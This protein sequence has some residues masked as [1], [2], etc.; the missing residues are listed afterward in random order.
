VAQLQ[1]HANERHFSIKRQ[2]TICYQTSV[3]TRLQHDNLVASLGHENV[4]AL[5][6]AFSTQWPVAAV[7]AESSAVDLAI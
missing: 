4:T 7:Q 3:L 5:P 2:N 1:A 6:I